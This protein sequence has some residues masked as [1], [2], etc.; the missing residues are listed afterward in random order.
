MQVIIH[1]PRAQAHGV[2][3]PPTGAQDGNTSMD[4]R[5]SLLVVLVAA[6]LPPAARGKPPAAIV[7]GPDV[8][9]DA[10]VRT[11]PALLDQRAPA[12]AFGAGLY[13]TVWLERNGPVQTIL[14]AR[15]DAQGKVLDDPAI[16]VAQDIS[17]DLPAVTFDGKR[18]LLTWVFNNK[19]NA[20]DIAAA[21][22]DPVSGKLAAPFNVV[23]KQQP[24]NNQAMAGGL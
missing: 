13:V 17:G 20:Q 7:G 6:A 21:Y 2:S 15:S 23:V 12:A 18:F 9:V 8:A 5:R 16:Q 19:T 3:S 10:P 14:A 22:L 4:V 24:Q 1:K 11:A